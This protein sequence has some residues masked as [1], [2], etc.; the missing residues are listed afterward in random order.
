VVLEFPVVV[1]VF[2]SPSPA[3]AWA[4]SP[5]ALALFLLPFPAVAREL[6][7]L[8]LVT[9]LVDVGPIPAAAPLFGASSTTSTC[10]RDS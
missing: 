9:L 5:A 3:V 10:R 2:L 7:P 8:T 6:F 1:A 4:S